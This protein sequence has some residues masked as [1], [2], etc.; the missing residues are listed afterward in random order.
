MAVVLGLLVALFYGSGDFFGGLAAKE[1]RA[2]AV[3]IGS[4]AVSAACLTV[5]TAGWAIAGGLPSPAH[6]DLLIGV[7]TGLI[8]PLSLGLL[9]RGLAMGRMSVMAP[10]TAVVA[11]IVPFT[12]GLLHGE[13]PPVVAIAGVAVALVAV[14]LIAGAPEPQD[15]TAPVRDPSTHPAAGVIPTAVVSGLGFGTIFVLLAQ[16]TDHAG[17]WPLL[18]AR[19]VAVTIAVTALLAWSRH[20]RVDYRP[21]ISPA[22]WRMV[23]ICCV[24]DIT[25]NG[26]YLAAAH[27]GLLSIVA[28]LSS[29]YPASTVLLARVVLGERLHR[30]QLA[31]LA[32]AT[33]GVV[34]MAAS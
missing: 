5:I 9:Y 31:G 26:I 14:G 7:A 17:L 22:S 8:A 19:I 16:T 28:V 4:F 2:S 10:V 15:E 3:V 13:R 11:A 27:R 33:A 34:A 30:A 6:A 20:R 1:S 32:L 18:V 29:L 25:A 21:A 23:A 24:F 12:W